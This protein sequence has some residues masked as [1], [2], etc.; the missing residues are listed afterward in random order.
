[1]EQVSETTWMV[2]YQ[3]KEEYVMEND[4]SNVVIAIW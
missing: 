4:C 3:V 1:V 2:T